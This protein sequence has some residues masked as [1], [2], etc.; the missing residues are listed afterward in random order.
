MRRLAFLA[1]CLAMASAPVRGYDLPVDLEL[2]L[3]VDVSDSIDQQQAALQREGYIGALTDPEVVS[4]MISGPFQR[5]AMLYVEWA[6]ADYQ[7]VVADWTLVE[8]GD[9]AE[10]FARVLA[11]EPVR[12]AQW[13]SISG[14]LDFAV[15]RFADNGFEG[16]R[17][18]IDISG[19]GANNHGRDLTTARAEA[20]AAGITINGLAIVGERMSR[21]GW[22]RSADVD[23]FYEH[24]VIGGPGA[25]MIVVD[26]PD[27][28]ASSIR[29]KLLREIASPG[30][31][32]PGGESGARLA[33]AR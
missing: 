24:H 1:L 31:E 15:A 12:R 10:A 13:T 33:E 22:P 21:Y 32:A 4:A 25:F 9:H 16:T 18:V 2:V 23:W 14:V 5:I 30:G 28:F 20:L 17:R 8:S 3:A 6:Q 27:A 26:S 19:D 11:T 29:R 7:R